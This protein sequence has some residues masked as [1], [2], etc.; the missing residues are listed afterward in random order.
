ML[1][2]PANVLDVGCGICPY[3]IFLAQQGLLAGRVV[4][5]DAS[6]I[7]LERAREIAQSAA[8]PHELIAGLASD[9]P[10][11]NS[12]FELVFSNDCLHFVIKWRRAVREIAR[13]LAPGARLLMVFSSMNIRERSMRW[14]DVVQILEEGGVEVRVDLHDPDDGYP[15]HCLLTGQKLA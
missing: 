5:L 6:S 7:A 14:G 12:S 13:V 9:L 8:V 10:F 11:A 3:T 15:P 4:G 1:Q 2:S